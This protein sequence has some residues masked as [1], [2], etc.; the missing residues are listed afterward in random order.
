MKIFKSLK[1]NLRFKTTL[2]K[3]I[4]YTFGETKLQKQ[5]EDVQ[6]RG[7]K[8][9]GNT[10]DLPNLIF[11][12]DLFDSIESWLPF[13]MNQKNSI[14]N[15]R[16]VFIVYPRN[17]G[18]SDYCND[19]MNYG[20]NVAKD[21]ERFMYENEITSATVGGHGLGAKTALLTG[22]YKNEIVTGYFGF[23]YSPMDYKYFEFAHTY[24]HILN[25]LSKI[26]MKSVNRN[27]LFHKLSEL[28]QSPKLLQLLK[29]KVSFQKG[30]GLNLKMNTEFINENL[31]MI[32]DWTPRYGLFGGRSLHV[33]P[34]HSSHVNLSTNTLPMYNICL[35]TEEY[36]QDVFAQ[37]T[38]CDNPEENHW[39][40][41]NKELSEGFR[42]RLT[43]F[44]EFYDGV[45]P[46]YKNRLDLFNGVKVPVIAE[47][48]VNK[49]SEEVPFHFHHNWRFQDK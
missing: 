47:E 20:E 33:F 39:I 2:E 34:E 29:D 18:F 4:K 45:H 8:I 49:V 6:L 27:A 11:F 5:T 7:I 21:V 32:L 40:Y 35:K 48:R 16:N 37:R 3:K 14:L 31:D 25:E 26:D 30:K 1:L 23:D 10:Q 13:F 17:L 22:C 38:E 19:K 28:V 43:K 44:L 42:E 36:N 46:L 24:R 15:H 12:P 41:E 9:T